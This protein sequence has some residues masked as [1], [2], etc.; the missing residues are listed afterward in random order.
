MASVQA[1]P[2]ENLWVRPSVCLV[3]GGG[4][5][6]AFSKDDRWLAF[7][8]LLGLHVWDWQDETSRVRTLSGKRGPIEWVGY[9]QIL[10][11]LDGGL[12]KWDLDQ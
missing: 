9:I 5:R 6:V 2:T 11:G 3:D 10:M 7:Q 1:V 12:G 8:N 4:F